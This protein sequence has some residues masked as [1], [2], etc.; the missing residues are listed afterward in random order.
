MSLEPRDSLLLY[1][2]GI[3]EASDPSGQEFGIAGLSLAARQRHGWSP[4]ELVAACLEDV[5]RYSHGA[6]PVDDQTLMVIQ[7]AD[8]A[9][10]SSN[11]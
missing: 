1:T 8:S 5:K 9:G 10:A 2:D 11:D 3:S 4:K 6:R 7:R